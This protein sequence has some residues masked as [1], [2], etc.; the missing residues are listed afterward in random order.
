MVPY[1]Y[2]FI[3][4]FLCLTPI[5]FFLEDLKKEWTPLDSKFTFPSNLKVLFLLPGPVL[6]RGKGFI[7][8]KVVKQNKEIISKLVNYKRQ[9]LRKNNGWTNEAKLVIR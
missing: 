7:C 8:L 3:L 5:S 6:E 1:A 2:C 9:D 4:S